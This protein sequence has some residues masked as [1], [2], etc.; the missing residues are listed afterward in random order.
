VPNRRDA[1]LGFAAFLKARG[2]GARPLKS[3]GLRIP[4]RQATTRVARR[5]AEPK[6]ANRMPSG[7]HERAGLAGSRDGR[8]LH[9][10]PHLTIF[11]RPS[12]RVR[13]FGGQRGRAVAVRAGQSV[14]RTGGRASRCRQESG[15]GERRTKGMAISILQVMQLLPSIAP[16]SACRGRPRASAPDRC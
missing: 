1:G 7:S 13:G 5:R 11:N 9:A 14:A 10:A 8:G 3:P 6:R 16:T 15:R 4:S 12:S 2:V